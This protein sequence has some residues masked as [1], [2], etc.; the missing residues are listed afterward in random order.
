VRGFGL[1]WYVLAV[2]E[3]PKMIARIWRGV[4]R[5]EDADE[6]VAYVQRTGIEGYRQTPG[7]QGRGCCAG[8]TATGWRSSR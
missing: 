5:A 2:W 3:D 7:N 1:R 6:Y 8:P 4:V